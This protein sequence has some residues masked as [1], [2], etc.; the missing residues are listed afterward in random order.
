MLTNNAYGQPIKI[1]LRAIPSGKH[2]SR[3]AFLLF[4][5]LFFYLTSMDAVKASDQ[6]F[7][8]AVAADPR[9]AKTSWLNALCE[10]RDMKATAQSSFLSPSWILVAGDIDPARDVYG[11]YLSAFPDTMRRPPLIPVVGNHDLGFENL[12]FIRDVMIPSI[13]GI[14]R[15]SP[16]ACDYYF[17]YKNVR[18]IL[19]DAYTENDAIGVIGI[20]GRK[21]VENVIAT[22]PVSVEHIFVA[23]H[24][25]AFPRGGHLTD[26]FNEKIEDR[27]A[28]WRMLTSSGRVRAVF[29]GH[30][31]A[32]SRLRVLNPQSAAANDS[33]AFP[34]EKGGVFQVD[35]GAAGHGKTNTFVRV[36]VD[37]SNVF[38]RA[39]ATEIGANQPF[40]GCDRWQS[41]S[42]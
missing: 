5:T 32:Y 23:F 39:Y 16:N 10:I 37:G 19:V 30:T 6:A 27:D 17:D 29:V 14:V 28:F 36:Q 15:R 1:N 9:A 4:F 22:S 38:Y 26:S 12:R 31:H 8:F 34:D 41:V 21:W 24:E 33:T 13:P 40:F 42:R 35:A 3:T 11:E 2:V 18:L 20:N 7:S 25:P